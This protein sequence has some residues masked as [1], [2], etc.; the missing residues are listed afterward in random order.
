MTRAVV[1]ALVFLGLGAGPAAAVNIKNVRSTYGPYGGVRPGNKL[2]QGDA[3][4][5]AYQI[6]D[7]TME[8]ETGLVKYTV[9]LEVLDSTGKQIL[10][11]PTPNQRHLT[12]GKGELSDRAQ[13]VIGS[14]YGPGKYS[15]RLTVTD[16]NIKGKE[17]GGGPSKTVKYDLQ[18]IKEDFGLIQAICPS[19]AATIQDFEANCVLTGMARDA[20]QIPKVEVRMT[21][22]DEKG[23]ATL[24]KPFI[25]NI[26]ADLPGIDFKKEKIIRMP[27]PIVVNRV[28]RYTVEI[29]AF[30][31]I[32]KK[33]AKVAFPL[34]VLE[35]SAVGAP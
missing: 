23:K 8:P 27:F 6:E 31:L 1:V 35:T 10:K 7:L 11:R 24:P 15:V 2:M 13:V 5:L 4:W 33:S 21:I 19:I 14:D 3:L 25:T 12:L 18:L 9:T 16:T 30:D 26:P 29:E 32:S 17:K 20:K 22:R 28:G 34:L